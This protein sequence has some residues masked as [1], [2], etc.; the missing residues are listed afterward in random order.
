V[1]RGDSRD[2]HCRQFFLGPN[3]QTFEKEFADYVG[4]KHTIGVAN[5]TDSLI[6]SLRAMGIGEGHEVIT[7]P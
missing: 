3:V 1:A 7:T 2:R 5:G 4:V 6:L